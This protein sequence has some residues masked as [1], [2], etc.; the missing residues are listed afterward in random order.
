MSKRGIAQSS[1]SIRSQKLAR[2]VRI[3]LVTDLHNCAF[4]KGQR[5]LL[6]AVCAARPDF[7]AFAGDIFDVHECEMHAVEALTTL[8]DRF[9]CYYVTGNHERHSGREEQI[10]R[11]VRRC[12]VTALQNGCAAV[13]AGDPS[14]LLYGLDDAPS[15]GALR[16]QRLQALD[17]R[18]D[19]HTFRILLH[20]R[21]EYYPLLL[22]GGFDLMLSGH[23]HGGQWRVP[24]APNGLFA[25]GQG[26]LPQFAG[27][28]YAFGERTLIVSRGLS[29]KPRLVPRLGNPPELVCV[30][31][32]PSGADH[33]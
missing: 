2:P 33:S 10:L 32:L 12:G 7:V 24:L 23:T 17:V 8:S 20:H 16:R 19:E 26:W 27:G 5:F 3:A 21:P 11:V 25:P 4:G 22:A 28:M 1:Y 13:C 29:K 30:S 9:P 14:I 18:A 6:D 15:H 31:L